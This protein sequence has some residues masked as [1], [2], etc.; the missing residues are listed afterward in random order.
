LSIFY[1]DRLIYYAQYPEIISDIQLDLT[2]SW[3]YLFRT[4]FSCWHG[5]I[6]TS[7]LHS[8]HYTNESEKTVIPVQQWTNTSQ[9]THRITHYIDGMLLSWNCNSDSL[10]FTNCTFIMDSNVHTRTLTAVR[11]VSYHL[12]AT[13]VQQLVNA[14]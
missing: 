4:R 9:Q 14:W 6:E 12:P 11:M 7:T 10:K 8:I 13:L 2:L 1:I 3:K 5:I